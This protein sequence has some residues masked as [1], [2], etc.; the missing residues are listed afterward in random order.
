M[1]LVEPA[2][3][4]ASPMRIVTVETD[5]TTGEAMRTNTPA[6]IESTYGKGKVIYLPHDISSSFFR[7]GHEH[8]ARM[9]ELA[10]REAASAPPPV[11]VTA[12]R[13]VQAMTHTQ[14]KRLV[15]HL[16]NDIS[17]IGRSQNVPGES[18][19]ERREVIP[20]HDITLTFR[21]K[22]LRRFQLVPGNK[23]LD[24]T[25]TKDGLQ[26]TVPRL[27]VHCMVVAE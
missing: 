12:P 5:K 13:I 22:N 2:K 9:M 4:G 11:E 8:W 3:G 25:D 27:D 17:S 10:L 23:K 16:L 18:L 21:D 6:I 24:A 26:V 1:L 20:I 15:V 14:G 7:F 19:Y